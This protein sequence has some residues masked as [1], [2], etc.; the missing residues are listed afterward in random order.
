MFCESVSPV[1]GSRVGGGTFIQR[2][3]QWSFVWYGCVGHGIG[4]D[5]MLGTGYRIH[6]QHKGVAYKCT[7]MIGSQY[8]QYHGVQK[9]RCPSTHSIKSLQYQ[10]PGNTQQTPVLGA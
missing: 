8:T 5:S 6:C 7:F 3:Q 1:Q 4:R 10:E 9:R 2:I